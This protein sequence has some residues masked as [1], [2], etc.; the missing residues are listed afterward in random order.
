MGSSTLLCLISDEGELQDM[1]RLVNPSLVEYSWI[2]LAKKR[3]VCQRSPVEQLSGVCL[4]HI[5]SFLS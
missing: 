1:Y 3:Y 2:R 4:D 5:T